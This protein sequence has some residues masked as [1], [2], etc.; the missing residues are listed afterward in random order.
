MSSQLIVIYFVHDRRSSIDHVNSLLD[1]DVADW[2]VTEGVNL[3]I[4][5]KVYCTW[6]NRLR[7]EVN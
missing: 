4:G 7:N 1:I 2:R 3:N 6:L 5:R